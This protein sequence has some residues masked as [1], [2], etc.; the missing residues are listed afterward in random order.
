MPRVPPRAGS[1]ARSP[2]PPPTHPSNHQ[3]HYKQQRRTCAM[4]FHTP[5]SPVSFQYMYASDDLVPAPARWFGGGCI[6]V[7]D[8]SDAPP[9]DIRG[10]TPLHT[11]TPPPVPTE[12]GPVRDQKTQTAHTVRVHD[13]GVLRVVGQH[14]GDDLAEGARVEALVDLLDRPVHVPLGRRDPSARVS[15]C[16]GVGVAV[17]WFNVWVCSTLYGYAH[18]T[19]C[20]V[21]AFNRLARLRTFLTTRPP[22][23]FLALAA[24]PLPCAYEC[25]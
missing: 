3:L 17:S 22:P 21:R 10:P 6:H 16:V 8:Q 24:C 2:S 14:V 9:F 18:C 25:G 5:R 23:T 12:P 4:P 15:D 7:S 13:D 1:R 19:G 20:A 11:H